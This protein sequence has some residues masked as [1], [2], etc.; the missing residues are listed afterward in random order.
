MVDSPLG[1]ADGREAGEVLGGRLVRLVRD[2]R[3]VV[4]EERVGWRVAANH[5]QGLLLEQKLLVQLARPQVHRG[6][7]CVRE[8]ARRAPQVDHRHPRSLR[9]EPSAGGLPSL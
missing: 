2:V 8:P 6:G 9:P 7:R 1:V 4:E 5:P 3:R